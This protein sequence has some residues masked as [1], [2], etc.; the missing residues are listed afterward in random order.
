MFKKQSP[1]VLFLTR[2]VKQAVVM[3]ALLEELGPIGK[4][5]CQSKFMLNNKSSEKIP[6]KATFSQTKFEEMRYTCLTLSSSDRKSV[7]ELVNYVYEF[8]GLV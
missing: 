4:Y 6:S 5:V 7:L 2:Q 1:K 3:G 8:H